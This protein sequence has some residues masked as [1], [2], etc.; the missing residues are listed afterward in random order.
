MPIALCLSLDDLEHAAKAVLTK[1]AWIYYSSAAEDLHTY[2]LNRRDWHRITFRP[3]VLRNVASV[4]MRRMILGHNSNL[5]IFIAPAA[6]ARLGHPDVSTA[7]SVSAED[8]ASW[9]QDNRASGCLYY[10][11]YVKKQRSETLSLI[12][13]AKA[14]GFTALLVTVDTPVVGKREDDD[15]YKAET[16]STEGQ[17]GELI[18]PQSSATWSGGEPVFRGPYSSTLSWEDLQ[19]IREAWKGKLCLKGIATVEDAVMAC[20]LGIESIYLSNHGGRQLDSAPS[21]LR[22]LLE[23][24]RWCPKVFDRCE[25]LIDGGIRR[26]NDVL[27]AIAL[28]ATGVGLGRPFMYALGAFGTE[29]VCKA[30]QILNEEIQS[31]M[32]LLGVARLDELGAQHINTR[33]LE[34]VT[35][36]DRKV[37]GFADSYGGFSEY[38]LANPISTVKIPAELSFEVAAPLFCAGITAY[39]ALLKVRSRPG[40]LV[41]IVGCGGVV[42]ITED[43]L[44]LA[45]RCGADETLNMLDATSSFEQAMSTIVITGANAAYNG[46]LGLTANHGVVIAVGLPAQD[47]QIA[48]PRWCAKDVSLITTSTGSREEMVEAL[49]IAAKHNFKPQIEVRS[50]QSI[51]EGYKDLAAGR[52]DGRL[53]YTFN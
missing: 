32:R 8:L 50:I 43:K 38:S 9:T 16:L 28:G 20:D 37:Q 17:S 52:V 23:I 45:K 11:L 5:P 46:A 24:R 7:S 25:V 4:D 26:G 36:G 19:W 47:L 22:T 33:E 30:I 42:D 1:R 6:L 41:N 48:L 13:R 49:E 35:L 14:L 39:S 2:H 15:R 3:R 29:G 27:K 53:V 34:N 10:Q 40:G 21:A 12:E 31:S 51:N 18:D 44:D